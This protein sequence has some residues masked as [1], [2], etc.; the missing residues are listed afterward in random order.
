MLLCVAPVQGM[1]ASCTVESLGKDKIHTAASMLDSVCINFGRFTENLRRLAG[2]QRRDLLQCA[3]CS[4]QV[5]TQHSHCVGMHRPSFCPVCPCRTFSSQL[6]SSTHPLHVT[7]PILFPLHTPAQRQAATSPSTS[8]NYVIFF[9]LLGLP[10]PPA[11]PPGYPLSC[12]TALA[13][14]SGAPSL[15]PLG[16]L[17]SWFA[18][19]T[20]SGFPTPCHT[21]KSAHNFESSSARGKGLVAETEAKRRASIAQAQKMAHGLG[22]HPEKCTQRKL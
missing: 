17:T 10:L 18:G 22:E 12:P 16:L 15:S 3:T 13:D 20:S 19:D 6:L 11:L 14:A 5:I 7:C 9:P 8:L 2:H 1:P 4:R 21:R